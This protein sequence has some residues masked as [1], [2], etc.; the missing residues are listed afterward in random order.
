MTKCERS[1]SNGISFAVC[2]LLLVVGSGCGDGQ[3]PIRAARGKVVCGGNP[4]TGGSV[5][6]SPVGETG[7]SEVGK[8]ATATVGE[9]GTFVLTTIKKFD[10]AVVGKHNVSYQPPEDIEEEE[11]DLAEGSA[12]ERAKNLDVLK[13]RRAEQK[14]KRCVQQGEIVVEVK[15]SGENEFTI[16]LVPVGR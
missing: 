12:Q 5:T 4:V 15:D 9:D 16:E 1:T 7:K 13:K 6:F 10:G 2:A 8:P 14:K 3:F 11:S